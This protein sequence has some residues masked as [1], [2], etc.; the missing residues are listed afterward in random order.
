MLNDLHLKP[1]ESKLMAREDFQYL[2][3]VKQLTPFLSREHTI[4]HCPDINKSMDAFV[5][6][7]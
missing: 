7:F 6:N 1:N 4:N 2:N 5:F 3:V